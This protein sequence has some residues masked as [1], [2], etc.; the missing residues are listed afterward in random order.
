[1]IHTTDPDTTGID[2]Y[3][4]TGGAP[5]GVLAAAALRCMGGQMQG[6]LLLNTGEKMARAIRMGIVNPAKVYRIDEMVR[7]NVLF[8]ATGVTDGNLLGGVR[9]RRDSVETH[10]LVMRSSSKTVREIKA[11]HQ[12]DDQF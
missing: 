4:G 2:I 10:T 12:D 7:G 9:F 6:R 5:E 3:L 11:R 8:S 1:M